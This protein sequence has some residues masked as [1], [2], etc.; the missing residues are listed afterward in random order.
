MVTKVSEVKFMTN[1]RELTI[2]NIKEAIAEE[3]AKPKPNNRYLTQVRQLEAAMEEGVIEPSSKPWISKRKLILAILLVLL[4]VLS[5][6]AAMA[7]PQILTGAL[8]SAASF[9]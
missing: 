7:D 6:L 3:E 2:A 4:V 9:G 1:A 5:I 8:P